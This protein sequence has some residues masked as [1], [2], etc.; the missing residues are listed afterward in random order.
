MGLTLQER[1]KALGE[2]KKLRLS[3][4]CFHARTDGV[5]FY[6]IG[7]TSPLGEGNRKK[8]LN[9]EYCSFWEIWKEPKPKIT[10][11]DVGRVAVLADGRRYLIVGFVSEAEYSVKLLVG[12]RKP[13]GIGMKSS[14]SPIV[15]VV[16]VGEE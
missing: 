10:A 11:L 14:H 13:D 1:F 9:L 4:W 6:D 7:S 5:K 2:G 16:N 15:R 12:I 8:L 3:Y